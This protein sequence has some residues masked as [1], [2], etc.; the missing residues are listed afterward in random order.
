[1]FPKLDI[2]MVMFAKGAPALEPGRACLLSHSEGQV[3]DR[4]GGTESSP[5]VGFGLNSGSLE[6]SGSRAH[7]PSARGGQTL[8][9]RKEEW[10]APTLKQPPQCPGGL[11][12]SRTPSRAWCCQAGQAPHPQTLLQHGPITPAPVPSLRLALSPVCLPSGQPVTI[13]SLTPAVMSQPSSSAVPMATV[14]HSQP[15]GAAGLLVKE[16]LQPQPAWVSGPLGPL[17]TTWGR[18]SSCVCPFIRW[19]FLCPTV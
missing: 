6:Q 10:G 2:S 7:F 18:G 1:M 3:G 4:G 12:E 11:G 14:C 16:E 19:V 17:Q 5:P 9:P 15:A 8:S 13:P